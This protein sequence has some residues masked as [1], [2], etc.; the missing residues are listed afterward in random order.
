MVRFLAETSD[1][2]ICC[3]IRTLPGS[4][5]KLSLSTPR[6]LWL[7]LCLT[8]MCSVPHILLTRIL[9]ERLQ[10]PPNYYR[11]PHSRGRDWSRLV[12][13]SF[14]QTH[15]VC[16]FKR[17]KQSSKSASNSG[18]DTAARGLRAAAPACLRQEADDLAR[19]PT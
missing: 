15:A 2:T 7:W 14:G 11:P 9:L 17:S 1:R 19:E 4:G 18:L 5:S 16:L 13:A 10:R 6:T 8:H 12:P 3:I